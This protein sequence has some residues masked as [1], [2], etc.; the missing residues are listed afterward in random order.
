[1]DYHFL[2]VE[3]KDGVTTLTL[4]RP[5]TLNSF[6]RPMAGE[7]QS[8]LASAA[9]DPSVRAILLTG[10]GRAFCAGQDLGAVVGPEGF[11]ETDLGAVVHDCYNPIIRALRAMPKPIV[12]AVNGVA[13]GAGAN[14][15]LACDVVVASTSASFLQAFSKIG[16]IPDSGGTY[17]LPRLVGWGRAS[18]LMML[19]E[20]VAA[21]DALAM[22]MIYKTFAP[23]EL[24]AAAQQ[25]AATLAAM[26]TRGLALTKQALNASAAND[27]VAQLDVEERLQREAGNT[28]DFREGVAAFL[29]KRAPRFTGR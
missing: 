20:K 6:H 12:A 28:E 26:P 18:A 27:V 3:T 4:N 10:A 8:A 29:Q 11:I 25:L 5:E 21:S 23:D 1:M 24:L 16:L 2:Q 13:A 7:L 9:G 19:A 17:V 22:G 14:L 15:A